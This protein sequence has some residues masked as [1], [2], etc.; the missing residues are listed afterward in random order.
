M[1][2]KELML[3]VARMS[4][5]SHMKNQEI[6]DAL[7]EEK[8]LTSRNARKVQEIIDEAGAWLLQEHERLAEIERAETVESHLAASLCE[9]FGLIDARVVAAGA[10]HTP[11]EYAALHRK[12]GRVAAEYFDKVASEAEDEG[13][14]LNVGIGG[15]Q[16]ALDFVS[17]LPERTRLNVNFY[18][19][20][21]IGRGNG[22]QAK[23]SSHVG[24]ETNTTIAWSRS[25]RLPK[26]L[27]YGTVPPFAIGIK[28]YCDLNPREAHKY[29]RELIATQ[30]DGLMAQDNIRRVVDDMNDN[31][32]LAI[33]GIGIVHPTEA[34]EHHGASHIERLCMTG[35]LKSLGF[36]TELLTQEGAA[37][38]FCYC[39][40]DAQ[41]K[42][43]PRWK[44]FLSAGDGTKHT[45][46]DY[47]RNLVARGK[48]VIVCAGPRK[49]AQLRIALD[50]KLLSVLVTD[51]HT[52]ETLLKA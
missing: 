19:F 20:A 2:S 7:F 26:H 27:Y 31:I 14:Q 42:G 12:F 50:A 30:I 33:A 5:E 8:L 3:R 47:F 21:M 16:S 41:G 25:G 29:C 44:F 37:G 23:F 4:H 34:D 46:V 48:K 39:L 9:K 38:E 32:N 24:P 28:D 45:G 35:L 1:A 36:D 43:D 11:P 17:C 49:E 15:G 51:S 10:T 6:A 13:E 18:A 22:R 52:A 40:F